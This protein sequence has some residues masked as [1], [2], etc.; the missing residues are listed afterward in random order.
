MATLERRG[1]CACLAG[2]LVEGRVSDTRA[3]LDL[4]LTS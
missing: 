2:A 1:R 3:L 4:R